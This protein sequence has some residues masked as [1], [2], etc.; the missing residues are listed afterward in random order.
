MKIRGQGVIAGV[1][2]TGDKFI[3]GN[4]ITGNNF[5]LVLFTQAKRSSPVSLTPEINIKL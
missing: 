5:S 4:N 2:D 3:A 1:N